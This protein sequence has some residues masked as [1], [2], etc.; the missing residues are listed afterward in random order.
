MKV[1]LKCFSTLVNPESCDFRNSTSYDME[2]G[3]TVE[4]LMKYADIAKKD[5]KIIFVNSRIV[6]AN[7]VLSD[8]DKV[9]FAPATGGM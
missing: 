3:Q 9:G 8:G 1:D 2:D 6:D 4:D 5:V 7:T